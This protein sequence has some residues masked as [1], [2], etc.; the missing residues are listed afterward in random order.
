MRVIAIKSEQQH[1][2]IKKVSLRLSLWLELE[3]FSGRETVICNRLPAPST[4]LPTPSMNTTHSSC[5]QSMMRAPPPIHATFFT[6]GDQFQWNATPCVEVMEGG[7][8]ADDGALG[9]KTK[10][11][12]TLTSLPYLCSCHTLL[13]IAKPLMSLCW[14]CCRSLAGCSICGHCLSEPYFTRMVTMTISSPAGFFK[15][16]RLV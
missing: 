4:P 9:M 14:I 16:I 8:E 15:E 6:A 13:L 10:A 11:G 1:V 3:S 2:V 7:R 5:L 12:Y